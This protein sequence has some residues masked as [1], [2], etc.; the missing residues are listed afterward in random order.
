M[1][2][3]KLFEKFKVKEIVF[4]AI[5]SA[6]TLVTCAVMPLV[7]SLQTVVFGIAQIVTGLQI[8]IFF[9][10]GLMRVRKTGT[11]FIMALLTGLFQLLM[12]P[13]MFFSNII[14]GILLEIFA[15][16]VFRGYKK[17]IA[18]FVTVL[19]Y[20]PLS[21]PFNVLYNYL[22]GRE[23]MVEVATRAPLTTVLLTLAV[24]AISAAGAAIGIK[25]AR[26]LQKSGVMKK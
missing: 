13:P 4:L 16:L 21:L 8:S 19:L 12:A 1:E 18:V 14:I 17:D 9:A 23:A 5:L 22:F 11:L 26:E 24:I 6:V 2:E 7:A 15:A 25:I 10:I 3:K 20:T